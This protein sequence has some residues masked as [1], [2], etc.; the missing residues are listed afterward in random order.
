MTDDQ[1][2]LTY[3]RDRSDKLEQQQYSLEGLIDLLRQS[4]EDDAQRVLARIRA[5]ESAKT[6][7]DEFRAGRFHADEA[8]A[9]HDSNVTDNGERR[10]ME[11]HSA[12]AK[13][14]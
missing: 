4:H 10:R 2:K 7:S 9:Q 1:R 12:R 6:L 5:G 8:H 3:L 11:A 14:F 13:Q